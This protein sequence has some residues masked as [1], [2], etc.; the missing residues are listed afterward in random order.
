LLKIHRNEHCEA[1]SSREWEQIHEKIVLL[2][3][4]QYGTQIWATFD[5]LR[6][7]MVQLSTPTSTP[8]ATMHSVTD[9]PTNRGTIHR[10]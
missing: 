8:S 4:M 2:N 9:R 1:A 3:T 6:N 10:A 7:K 5:R